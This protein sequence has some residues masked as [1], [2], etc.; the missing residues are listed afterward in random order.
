MG[1]NIRSVIWV[2]LWRTGPRD[3]SEQCRPSQKCVV[4]HRTTPSR[5]RCSKKCAETVSYPCSKL[6]N[7]CSKKLCR[8]SFIFLFQT[9]DGLEVRVPWSHLRLGPVGF[10][11]ACFVKSY[12]LGRGRVCVSLIWLDCLRWL[13]WEAAPSLRPVRPAV[14]L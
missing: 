14:W 11:P 6:S 9:S 8:N 5:H 7:Q 13:C 1:V 4:Y 2:H 3:G 12:S 10:E